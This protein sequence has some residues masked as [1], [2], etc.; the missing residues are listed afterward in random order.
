MTQSNDRG[1]QLHQQG[2]HFGGPVGDE[3]YGYQG[4]DRNEPL[5]SGFGGGKGSEFGPG[6][7]GDH[8]SD[9]NQRASGHAG[10]GNQARGR[11][12]N[13]HQQFADAGGSSGQADHRGRGPKSYLRSDARITEDL[14][15]KLTDDP[16]IDASEIH[17]EVK[18]GVVTL[19]GTVEK[20]SMK[21]RAEDLAERCSGA[22]D[23]HNQIRVKSFGSGLN[24]RN[25]PETAR[26]DSELQGKAQ[27]KS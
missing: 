20:R 22:K 24:T 1:R 16:M 11:D 3:A 9:T 26:L 15:E 4:Q 10:A 17:V 13:A 7:R 18:E 25:D 5:R 14:N 2:S 12:G 8:G 6:Q 19:T 27:A 23:V 21:H